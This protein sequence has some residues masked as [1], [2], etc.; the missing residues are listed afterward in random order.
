VVTGGSAI[1]AYLALFGLLALSWAG[2]PTA[3][4]AAL[5]AAGVL[6]SQGDLNIYLVLTVG[7]AASVLGGIVAYLIGRG[8]GRPAIT[9]PGPLLQWRTRA[10]AR[11]E[12]LFD[13]YGAVAVFVVPMWLAG[14]HQM[15]WRSFLVWNALAALAWTVVAGLGGYFVGPAFGDALRRGSFWLAAAVALLVICAIAYHYLVVRRRPSEPGS[16]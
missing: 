4:Q 3:G 10:L 12:R 15:P 9:A 7:S 13:R 5:V 11:G 2:L 8:G 14:I 16:R 6:A 1:G